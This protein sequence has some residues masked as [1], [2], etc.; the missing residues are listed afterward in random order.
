MTTKNDLFEQSIRHIPQLDVNN[1]RLI[2]DGYVARPLTL[3]YPT[4]TSLPMTSTTTVLF[5]LGHTPE[6]PMMAEAVWDGVPMSEIL[7]RTTPQATARYANFNSG[8]GYTTSLPLE[9]L[10]GALLVHSLNGKALPNAHGFPARVVVPGLAGYKM[11]KWITHITITD[12]P[13]TG[14]WERRG[15]P[16]DGSITPIVSIDALAAPVAYGEP[17]TLSGQGYAGQQAIAAIRISVD[18]NAPT[19]I[20]YT[21]GGAQ[22]LAHWHTAW[23][24]STPGVFNVQVQLEA[25]DG[26]TTTAQT[27]IEVRA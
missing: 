21:G 3:D 5:C 10:Q 26:Q 17:V 20:E 6:S 9:T 1:W 22:R 12:Q 25:D 2:V 19:V 13:K 18:G 11:P 7:N 23:N 4:L 14:F 27:V 24:P 16:D 8:D 15:A